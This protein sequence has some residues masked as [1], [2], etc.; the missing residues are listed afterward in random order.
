MPYFQLKS[1]PTGD[2]AS[3]IT[4]LPDVTEPARES[5]VDGTG[6]RRSL[7][8]TAVAL[9]RMIALVWR[10]GPWLTVSLAVATILAA[11]VPATTALIARLL[12]NSVA[13]AIAVHRAHLPDRGVVGPIVGFAVHT[14]ATDAIVGTIVLQLLVFLVAALT[15]ALR[16]M[17][18]QLLQQKVTQRVQL[19]V[20]R[21]ASRL[22]LA[23]FEDAKS[24]DLLRQAQQEA[25]TRPVTMIENLYGLVQNVITFASVV[26]LLVTLNPWVALAALAAPVPAFVVDSRFGKS[27]FQVSMWSSPIRRRMQYLSTLV[28]T[29]TYAKEVK[30]FGLGDYFAERFRTLGEVFY[31][32]LRRQIG[33][34]NLASAL[35]GTLTQ[36]VTAL[37]YL[38]VALLAVSGRLSLGDLVMYTA[39]AATVQMSAQAM[40][41]G[42]TGMYENNLYLDTLYRMLR[43]RPT[44][45]CPA[46]P[47]PVPEP[48]RG[49]IR[50]EHVSFTY[51]GAAGP[52]LR[53]LTFDIP[54]GQTMAVVGR[55][56]AG[57]ST[58]VKLVC[59]LYDPTEG[60]ILLDGVDLRDMDPDE[61]RA[62]I[63][64][65]FQDYATYQATAAENIGLGD[66]RHIGDRAS[67]E[68]AA[69][70]GG[71]HE[72]I[73]RMSHGYDTPLGTWFS[74]GVNLSGGEWQKIAL[75]RAFLRDSRILVFDEPTSA[76]D[77]ASEYD[78]FTRLRDL[79]D[80]RTTLYV[81]HR[82]S[83]VRR[84]D[85]IVLMSGGHATEQGTHAELL[86]LGGEYAHLF[87]TQASAYVDLAVS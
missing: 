65:T 54:P 34:R 41:S 63:S 64:G 38:Y 15:G 19:G 25:A 70:R 67:I 79:A 46:D 44:I 84:A 29:D 80:G 17:A 20:M 57:K 68:T 69:T 6:P 74:G 56:G 60:R 30:L 43:T 51:P 66:L 50:V 75:S 82:F 10:A 78:L 13:Q 59:R 49:H 27:G 85:R 7:V 37:T 76:L 81:S 3:G 39:A 77:P 24:Y 23:F 26:A 11:L 12:I 21:H 45:T 83:T 62:R 22:E 1:T 86:A 53:D 28:T 32:R 36:V 55:N 16:T 61:L 87:R 8:A 14:T 18:G 40:F 58:L 33:G 5:A 2:P 47:V 35:L 42:I 52:A 48:L 71:A 9:P 4:G 31:R 72:L 73:S